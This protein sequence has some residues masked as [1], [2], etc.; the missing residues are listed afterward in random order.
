[1]KNA[2][3]LLFLTCVAAGALVAGPAFHR[4]AMSA[5]VSAS[6]SQPSPQS[7][8]TIASVVDRDIDA[9]EKQ[10]VDAAEAMP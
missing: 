6:G 8:P 10:V 5:V 3:I 7:A 4:A 1:M 2:R 9:V